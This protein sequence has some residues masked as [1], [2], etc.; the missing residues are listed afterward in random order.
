MLTSL[1][2]KAE[3]QSSGER[4]RLKR[5]LSGK[6]HRIRVTEA[7]VNYVGSV[8]ID[9]DFMDAAG[10]QMNQEVHVVNATNGERWITYAIPAKRGS[11]TMSLNGGGA[12]KGVIGDIL[13]VMVYD[14]TDEPTTPKVVFFGDENKVLKVGTTEIHGTIHPDLQE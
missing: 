6:L 3:Q 1:P 13:I 2:R 8:G 7:Q 12:R 4:M 9:Q 11:K 5:L 10:I 14:W